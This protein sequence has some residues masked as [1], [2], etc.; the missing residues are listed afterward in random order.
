MK[1]LLLTLAGAV[2][3]LCASALTVTPDQLT[4][5][6]ASTIDGFT[7][8]IQKQN[9]QTAPQVFGEALRT[10]AKNTV[11][12]SGSKITKVVFTLSDSGSKRYTTFTPRTGEYTAAQAEG[13]TQLTWTGDA[14]SVTF[15]VGDKATM[16]SDG[17]T[18]AGQIHI[19]SIQ[20][21]GEGG[22]GETP[23]P[24]EGEYRIT[25]SE[26]TVPGV[27]N[28][29][30][31][32]FNVEQGEG[33][34]APMFHGN[35]KAIRLYAKNTIS[36]EAEELTKITFV[37]SSD[38]NFRYTVVTPSVGEITPA[39]AA[40][41]TEFTW[42]GNAQEVVFTVGEIAT[43]GEESDKNG[44]IRFTE[45]VIEGT[46]GEVVEVPTPELPSFVLA[47]SVE[48]GKKYVLAADGKVAASL[49][50]KT[51]GYLSMAAATFDGNICKTAEANA[52]T[53]TP[54]GDAYYMQDAEGFYYY[55]TGTYNS[56]NKSED[57][58][59]EGGLWTISVAEDGAATITNTSVKK[60]ISYSTTF[61]SYGS[62]AEVGENILPT[63]YVYDE[64]VGVAAVEAAENAAV[65][66]FNLQGV[67][68]ANPSNGLYIRRQG[69]QV[70][71]VLVK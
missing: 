8:D 70:S 15:T 50:T 32:N 33:G 19:A 67:R 46:P 2:F 14:A 7:V 31:F 48:A 41:D 65:E 64:T 10:Y 5:P 3:S 18:K 6:G 40:G 22:T 53:F 24:V 69:N 71:K 55:Q 21:E 20:I 37:L 62:Y 54:E 58:P 38:A 36:V 51:Y 26:I 11:T 30:G 52:F 56:F 35:T 34:T 28:V 25:A 23:E 1:K 13:D 57:V 16:G 49:G 45:L 47:T 4:V 17:D 60:I 29:E 27:S 66:Y 39:Q 68:V 43:L 9:G 63:L 12:I 59:E 61:T 44:Q 42:V